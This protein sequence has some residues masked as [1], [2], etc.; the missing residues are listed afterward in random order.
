ML[1]PRLLFSFAPLWIGVA[2][3]GCAHTHNFST[4]PTQA[5]VRTTLRGIEGKDV[6][7]TLRSG[8][9]AYGEVKALDPDTLRLSTGDRPTEMGI[10][11][12]DIQKITVFN[13][14]NAVATGAGIA[15]GAITAFKLAEYVA[16]HDVPIGLLSEIPGPL[17][18]PVTLG[19]GAAVGGTIA[20]LLFP[21]S[22]TYI[23]Q[24]SRPDTVL[25]LVDR[26][27]EDGEKSIRVRIRHQSYTLPKAQCEVLMQPDRVYLKASRTAFRKAR[28][29]I[30]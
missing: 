23:Y 7:V 13:H 1:Y 5:E 3:C 17:V 16:T 6:G 12:L 30:L 28:I 4:T 21:A 19:L 10:P 27:L 20:S 9:Q 11:C 2:L 25:L 15:L 18:I 8:V 29:P 26:V 24:F 22:D 14:G